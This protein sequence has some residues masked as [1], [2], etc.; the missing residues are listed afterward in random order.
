M[1]KMMRW[2]SS[3]PLIWPLPGQ[4]KPT[5]SR[6]VCS[7]SPSFEYNERAWTKYE[8]DTEFLWGPNQEAVQLGKNTMHLML[9]NPFPYSREKFIKMNFQWDGDEPFTREPTRVPERSCTIM[10]PFE[11]QNGQCR[12]DI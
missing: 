3:S 5:M 6:P 8:V 11:R 2:C 10:A 12:V 4:T 1:F 7:L 9:F